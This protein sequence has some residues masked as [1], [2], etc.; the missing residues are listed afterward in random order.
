[1]TIYKF[2]FF[3]KMIFLLFP[4]VSKHIDNFYY[5]IIRPS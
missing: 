3:K 2:I 4:N 1:M 5:L